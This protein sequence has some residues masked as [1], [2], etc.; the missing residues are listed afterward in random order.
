MNSPQIRSLAD[1]LIGEGY[2]A[3][4]YIRNTNTHCA[5]KPMLTTAGL[6]VGLDWTW[7]VKRYCYET[8]E[9]ATEALRAWDGKGDPP[10]LWIKEKP[11]DRLGPGAG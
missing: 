2:C 5:V 11:S 4:R 1:F 6:F 9:E 7:Y 3:V 10:G 8:A